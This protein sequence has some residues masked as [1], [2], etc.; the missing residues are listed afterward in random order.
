MAMRRI[1]IVRIHIDFEGSVSDD[2]RHER[3]SSMKFKHKRSFESMLAYSPSKS[4]SFKSVTNIWPGLCVINSGQ[5]ATTATACG[6]T[7][8]AQKT[9]TSPGLISTGSP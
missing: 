5:H 4:V 6:A 1:V 8:H 7:P 3:T 2:A 9:G